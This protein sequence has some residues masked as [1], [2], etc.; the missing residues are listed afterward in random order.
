M[1]R[2]IYGMPSDAV[3][4]FDG[5]SGSLKADGNC[6]SERVARASARSS[7][8]AMSPGAGKHRAEGSPDLP[9]SG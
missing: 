5:C 9:T 2:R 1:R 8:G 7:R 3:N 6:N 4:K